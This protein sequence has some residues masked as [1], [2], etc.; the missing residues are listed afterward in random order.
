MET[1]DIEKIYALQDRVLLTVFSMETSFY[2]TGGTCLHRFYWET[3]Y[4]YDLDLF[5]SD[6]ALY[7][8]DVRIAL[9]ALASEKLAFEVQVDTRDFT[10]ILVESFLKVDFVNDRVHRAGRSIRTESGVV[11]DN[12]INL[13]ANKI[14]AVLGRDEPKDVL[15]LYTIFRHGHPDWEEIARASRK[16]CVW[17]PELLEF[18]LKSF[19]LSLLDLLHTPDPSVIQD[20]KNLYQKMVEEILKPA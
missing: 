16:K 2:L 4:S 14:C 15:D 3:R 1:L 11:I 6:N 9:D 18:R 10:R 12:L 13:A 17:D 19:P 20:A 8:E 5:S 7:R